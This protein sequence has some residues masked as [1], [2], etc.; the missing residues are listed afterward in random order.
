LDQIRAERFLS[1]EEIEERIARQ[2]ILPQNRPGVDRILE[3]D[4]QL[5]N[6]EA[7]LEDEAVRING[8]LRVTILYIPEDNLGTVKS[9]DRRLSFSRVVSVR[10]P[11]RV[12]EID[13]AL[14]IEEVDTN[15]IDPY[16]IRLT[17]IISGQL[18]FLGIEDIELFPGDDRVEVITDRFGIDEVVGEREFTTEVRR[19]V[20]ISEESLDVERI[21]NIQSTIRLINAKIN[22]NQVE[23][24]AEIRSQILYES[25]GGRVRSL[26]ITTP[27]TERIRIQG[28]REGMRVFADL[29]IV[30]QSVRII[31]SNTLRV[32]YEVGIKVLVLERGE[33]ELPIDINGD[34]FPRRETILVERIVARRQTRVLAEDELEVADPGASRVVRVT[35][36]VNSASIETDVDTGGVFISGE[37][38]ANVLYVA[39]EPSQQ[40]FF[41]GDRLF[42]DEF[43]SIPGLSPDGVRVY[44]E[45][46]VIRSEGEVE[47]SNIIQVE[48][49]LGIEVLVTELVEVPVVRGITTEE[50]EIVEPPTEERVYIVKSGDTLF[51]IAQRFNVTT[52]EI[53]AANDITN[54]DQLSIGQRLIIPN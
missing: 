49:L 2:I 36:D 54:P 9:I 42:F 15:I 32:S 23:I 11:N 1:Q 38:T 25:T 29:E 13:P 21:L 35:A 40:V 44:P 39:N 14:V 10:L 46:R 53:I 52:D 6:V 16:N 20:E 31:D 18:R 12:I 33:I 24:Q 17:I 27:F 19:R 47:D 43:I 26:N 4:V 22:R 8:T 34:F 5:E 30:D 7:E 41:I 48:V 37:V 3:T 50:K 51:K 28:V 45:V